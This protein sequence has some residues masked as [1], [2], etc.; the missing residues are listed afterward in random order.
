MFPATLFDFNGVL[1]DDERVHL[2]AFR[3]ALRP[4]NVDV[5]ERDYFEKYLGYDD[6]GAFEAILHDTGRSATRTELER[7]VASKRPLY[8]ARAVEE[9]ELFEGAAELVELCADNGPVGIVSGALTDEIEYGLKRL[10]VER[11]VGKVIS[12]EHTTRSKPDPEGYR[13][14]VSWLEEQMGAAASQA[15]VIEDSIDGINAAKDVEL[16]TVAVAHSYPQGKLR[17]SRADLVVERVAD[18]TREVLADLYRRL[19]G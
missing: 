6:M 3:D 9:L 1:V 11:L 10:G 7:L 12:A 4:M 16:P 8:M 15:L 13:M 19:Y 2:E 14:G 18:I 5:S 17:E